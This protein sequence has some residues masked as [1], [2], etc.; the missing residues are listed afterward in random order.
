MMQFEIRAARV[1]LLDHSGAFRDAAAVL[2]AA[3]VPE[4]NSGSVSP[5]WLRAHTP[6]IS[7]VQFTF[8]EQRRA[9]IREV[10]RRPLGDAEAGYGVQLLSWARRRVRPCARQAPKALRMAGGPEN[11]RRL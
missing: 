4:R 1:G 9:R 8:I 11:A 5:L 10:V 2:G 6:A 3:Y 7:P